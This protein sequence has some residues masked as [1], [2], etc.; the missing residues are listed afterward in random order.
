MTT[1]NVAN[2]LISFPCASKEANMIFA[3]KSVLTATTQSH[4]YAMPNVGARHTLPPRTPRHFARI[5][6]KVFARILGS[7]RDPVL[8]IQQES[9]FSLEILAK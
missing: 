7:L 9:L 4:K 6:L 8:E 1:T 3:F 5:P 2:F